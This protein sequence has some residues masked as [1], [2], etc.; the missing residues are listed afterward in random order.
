LYS[1]TLC[2]IE[3]ILLKVQK[4]VPFRLM[5][6]N[7]QVFDIDILKKNKVIRDYFYNSGKQN[8]FD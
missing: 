3:S 7:L 6:W 1:V 5:A 8:G 4:I 2:F